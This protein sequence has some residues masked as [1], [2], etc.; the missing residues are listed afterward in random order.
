MR[1]CDLGGMCQGV[2]MGQGCP[3]M[4]QGMMGQGT[5]GQGMGQG[6]MM[7]MMGDQ[8]GMP[9]MMAG[10]GSGAGMGSDDGGM[11]GPN[12][13]RLMFALL[14]ADGDGALSPP[15]FQAARDRIFNA[16]DGVGAGGLTRAEK[17]GVIRDPRKD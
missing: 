15:A 8:G 12:M 11:R 13:M 5:M 17:T 14:D 7:G 10:R 16:A 6:G 2:A 4:G 3:M 1:V 9:G